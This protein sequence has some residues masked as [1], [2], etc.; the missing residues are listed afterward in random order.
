MVSNDLIIN[1]E[2]LKS[3]GSYLVNLG[4]KMDSFVSEYIHILQEIQNTAIISGEV[5]EALYIFIEYVQK[6]NNQIG[7]I[8]ASV[9]TQIDKFLERIDSEDQYLF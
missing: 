4:E 8:S 7:D 6:L 2:Y 5:S 1:D 9:K 3:M